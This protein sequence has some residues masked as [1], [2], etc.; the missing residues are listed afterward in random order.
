MKQKTAILLLAL[1]GMTQAVAQEYEYVPFVREGVKW[2]Y[3]ICDDFTVDFPTNPTR[4][5]NIYYRTL[6][7]R[8]D[9][10]INGKTYKA[11]HKCVD[12]EMSEPSEVIPM[13]LREEGK[14]VYG[15]VPDGKFYDDAPIG[16][17]RFGTDEYFDAIHSGQEFLLY[18]FQDPVAY[19]DSINQQA[20]PG[21]QYPSLLVD[22]IV[23]GDHLAKRYIIDDYYRDQFIEGIGWAAVHCY[24]LGFHIPT[25]EQPHKEVYE[26]LNV[27]ENG[28]MVYRSRNSDIYD[29]NYMPLI[30]E[31]VKW[32]NER[33]TVINGD[34]TCCYYT[35]EF[36]GNYPEVDDNGFTY[37]AMYRYDGRHHEVDVNADSLVVG[38]R[39][40]FSSLYFY[41]NEPWNQIVNQGRNMLDFNNVTPYYD[42]GMLYHR[43][44][45]P[46]WCSV[47]FEYCSQDILFWDE[48]CDCERIMIDG[49]ECFREIYTGPD[50]KPR[51]YV[52]EGIGFDS[53]DLGDLLTPFTRKPDPDADYQQWC[54]LSHVIKDGKVIYKGMRYRD[55]ADGIDEVVT[56]KTC[57]SLDPNY[58]N[59]MGQPVGKEIPTVP[60]IYIHQGKKICVSRMQ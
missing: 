10:V 30:R 55:G 3:T 24:P 28:N 58:Y 42:P 5:D 26:L 20:N 19:W 46:G 4:G 34:T 1:L 25:Q 52:V 33:V 35:Y 21:Q 54:G 40:N 44:Q 45:T 9:T 60:G 41:R 38:L 32:V 15:I 18:D 47:Y 59:L 31:G 11:M 50:G 14:K 39:E 12:D 2:T 17:F 36:K 43:L 8:G 51:A 37:K 48:I 23:V 16:D 29:H 6:E 22:T 7:F 57:C 49:Y 56:D 13:Y 27:V 53:Y